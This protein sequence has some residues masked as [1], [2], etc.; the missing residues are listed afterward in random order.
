MVQLPPRPPQKNSHFSKYSS[1]D[2][3]IPK[4][5]P[6]WST[7]SS[8][9]RAYVQ[10]DVPTS[11]D[12]DPGCWGGWCFSMPA[13]RDADFTTCSDFRGILRLQR[14]RRFGSGF[15]PGIDCRPI[16]MRLAVMGS[17]K[18]RF[19]K[20]N[21]ST[22]CRREVP[23]LLR[24]GIFRSTSWQLV[25]TCIHTFVA[26]QFA[27]NFHRLHSAHGVLTR[28]EELT[29]IMNVLRNTTR[30]YPLVICYIAIENGHRNSWFS[31]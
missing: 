10:V 6:K 17:W 3:G 13:P 1:T 5:Y 14:Q 21:L 19:F 2:F 22:K 16:H 25:F 15:G 11:G 30:H 18:Y 29:N 24:K 28:H 23:A 7:P 8:Y 26:S 9:W 4:I 12:P 27:A 31:H 20:L